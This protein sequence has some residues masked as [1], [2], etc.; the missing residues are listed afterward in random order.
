MK[1]W[2]SSKIG[3]RIVALVLV[4][5]V[6]SIVTVTAIFA[7]LQLN[8]TIANRR[9]SIEATGYVFA[10]AI[11][12]HVAKG[13]SAE[14]LKVLRSI[15]RVP[16]VSYAA[17]LDAENREIAALGSTV[18][19]AAD[20][21]PDEPRI[22]TM[23]ARGS[24]PVAVEIVKGGRP[25]G[26]L[27]IVADVSS[28]RDGLLRDALVM[29]LTAFAAAMF[30]LATAA[31]LQRRITRPI[32]SLTETMRRIGETRDYTAKVEHVAEDETGALVDSFNGMISE[33]ALRDRKL[34][35]LAYHD[36]LTG[37]ANRQ[38]FHLNLERTLARGSAHAA[39]LLLDLDGFKNVNDT[40]GHSVGDALLI[41]VAKTVETELPP[42]MQLARLGGDEFAVIAP[43]IASEQGA[44]G[45]AARIMAALLKPVVIDQREI[46]VS[47]SIGIVLVPRDGA[48][49]EELL[50]RADLALYCAKRE[51]P[52]RV[53][54][55]RPALDE[56]VQRRSELARDL[57][58]ALDA[59]SLEVHYQP[60]VDL[61]TGEVVGFEALL[62]WKHPERGYVSPA[63]FV[64]IAE[65][66]N[67]ICELGLWVLRESCRQLVAWIDA[68]HMPRQVS[69]NV[70]MAQIRQAEFH[71]DV[72][73]ILRQ[74][75]LRPSL[76]CFEL[77]ES[78]FIGTSRRRADYILEALKQAGVTLAIDDFGTGYSS[79]SYL[80]ELPFDKLKI[81]RAFIAGIDVDSDKRRLFKGIV[82][83]GHA[84][85][86]SIVAEGA[87]TNGEVKV[88]QQLHADQVQGYIFSRPL[89]AAEAL[90]AAT[91]IT[92]E[93]GHRF[94]STD[95][96]R[97]AG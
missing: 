91:S 20:L 60:Q 66:S 93:F 59:G 4:S 21:S 69:V 64:P 71:L 62:R 33:I 27:I 34:E 23:L 40:F 3:R 51:G 80:R 63:I 2:G 14:A 77:T 89:P 84:L 68:G 53:K 47:T 41:A 10:S 87:E 65:E 73:E 54:F 36:Q 12:D 31:R 49:P 7:S 88:L 52:S 46:F 85:G 6:L 25:V 95:D 55:Y 96:L 8:E 39:L 97:R 24:F 81:D 82:D 42:E 67:L 45:V 43:D 30:G 78:M 11:A 61:A 74:T 15:T 28:L 79:L 26:R 38:L 57:R 58:R 19:A 50:R 48:S 56:D 22:L 5:V 76:L 37:A 86:K 75:G 17:A 35:R 92:E 72:G 83:L 32:L 94:A 18:L 90:A 13:D 70:S 1:L 16:D 29:V 44:E 9:A